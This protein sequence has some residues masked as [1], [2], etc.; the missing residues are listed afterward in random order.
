ML[1]TD[2]EDRTR[3][4]RLAPAVRSGSTAERRLRFQVAVRTP[5]LFSAGVRDMNKPEQISVAP[6]REGDAPHGT[7]GATGGPG[8]GF[9]S[10]FTRCLPETWRS[11][12]CP[13]TA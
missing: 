11:R 10:I 12:R 3:R 4:H 6:N 7:P 8:W 2:V 9:G 1:P 13:I 5:K